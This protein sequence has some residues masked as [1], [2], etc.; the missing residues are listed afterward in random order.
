MIIEIDQ[1]MKTPT[2]LCPGLSD[3]M[4]DIASRIQN[5]YTEHAFAEIEKEINYVF[6]NKAYLITAFSH[7]S[8]INNRLTQPYERYLK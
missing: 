2:V 5:F 1:V 4:D 8:Y 3:T 6:Q 7:P